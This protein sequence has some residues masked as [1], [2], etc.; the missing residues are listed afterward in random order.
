MDAYRGCPESDGRFLGKEGGI[1]KE[2]RLLEV[3]LTFF[4]ESRNTGFELGAAS[5][6]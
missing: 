3:R 2:G 5:Y 1:V 4:T 6:G